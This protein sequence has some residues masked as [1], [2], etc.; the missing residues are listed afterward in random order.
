MAN[1]THMT[2]ANLN[3]RVGSRIRE[4]PFPFDSSA[5]LSVESFV[6]MAVASV[7]SLALSVAASKVFS[8]SDRLS[9]L[10]I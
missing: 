4:K 1:F 8:S 3:N 2:I 7:D 5:V 10:V 9:S 6:E